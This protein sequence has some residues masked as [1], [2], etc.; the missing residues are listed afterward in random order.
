MGGQNDLKIM[1][2]RNEWVGNF[3]NN[4]PDLFMVVSLKV[5]IN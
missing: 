1:I 2:K 4:G 3:I 5:V